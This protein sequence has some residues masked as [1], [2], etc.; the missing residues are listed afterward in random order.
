MKKKIEIF[1]LLVFS[2]SVT[3]VNLASAQGTASP[4]EVQK[5]GIEAYN[6][7]NYDQAIDLL[8]QATMSG[9]LSRYDQ[10][11]GLSYLAACYIDKNDKKG[12]ETAIARIVDIDLGHQLDETVFESGVTQTY[13]DARDRIAANRIEG[14]MIETDPAGATIVMDGFQKI[15]QTPVLF[16][17]LSSG[18]HTFRF[19]RAGCDPMTQTL[20]VSSGMENSA[21]SFELTCGEVIPMPRARQ[22][23][24]EAVRQ[25]AKTTLVSG[26]SAYDELEYDDAIRKLFE[27]V[28]SGGLDRNDQ[29]NGLAYLAACHLSKR[30]DRLIKEAV[31]KRIVDIDSQYKLTQAA[32]FPQWMTEEYRLIRDQLF[33]KSHKNVSFVSN[34]P[35]ALVLMDGYF[36]NGATQMDLSAL[37]EG[38]KS[39][40]LNR[41]NCMTAT[42]IN[43][44][45][46]D[47]ANRKVT[48]QLSCQ[49]PT[50]VTVPSDKSI[51][52]EG[53]LE[54][55]IV[56]FEQQRY[57]KA[58]SFLNIATTSGQLEKFDQIKAL[59]YL[60]ACQILEDK[61]DDLTLTIKRLVDIDKNHKINSAI[62]EKDV[63]ET[64]SAYHSQIVN[65]VVKNIRIVSSPPGAT[66]KIDGIVQIGHTPMTLVSLTTGAH[67][68]ILQ[69]ETCKTAP[70][71]VTIAAN[72]SNQDI[73]FD[74]KSCDYQM[75]EPVTELTAR[76]ALETLNQ[77][78]TAYDDFEY[79]T[80]ILKLFEAVNSGKLDPAA[81]L[82]GLGY[83]TAIYISEKGDQE[84]KAALIGRIVDVNPKHDLAD[85]FPEWIR[86]EY[87]LLRQEV[88]QSSLKGVTLTSN[89]SGVRV[90]MDG[91]FR[92][93]KTPMTLPYLSPGEHAF[94]LQKEDCTAATIIRDVTPDFS[95]NE[96]S[97]ELSCQEPFPVIIP[98]FAAIAATAVKAAID[99]QA[100]AAQPTMPSS[101]AGTS[102]GAA[103]GTSSGLSTKALLIGGGVLIAG[104]IAAVVVSGSDD[105]SDQP[106]GLPRPPGLD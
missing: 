61:K 26:I 41:E 105:T 28:D 18:K 24:T 27:A 77:G 102:G 38:S 85:I 19:E 67:T 46:P 59:E 97:F 3:L 44:V 103:S 22:I 14:V 31:I 11:Q 25:S 23:P 43:E 91:F 36:R 106:R 39:F 56:Q 9:A 45:V 83:L 90:M 15:G 64:Y 81:Q 4:V 52:I 1:L 51:S 73:S 60:T 40:I 57:V 7:F 16:A 88:L 75:I 54:K 30:S 13:R 42:I 100:A 35:G 66:V 99:A 32:S 71:A 33:E 53:I 79:E 8:E 86:S 101:V 76:A 6:Q 49:D 63:I 78:I 17:L 87:D 65:D 104:G 89:P 84:S 62:F 69:R 2:L 72:H 93:E 50:L 94:I 74:L 92:W 5:Q 21:V 48:F 96:I 98:T 82:K 95:R 47:L 37:T 58:I 68:F 12:V 80:A 29:L 10:L 34:P 55:G 20:R 70:R